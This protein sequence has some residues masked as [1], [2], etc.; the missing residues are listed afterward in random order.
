MEKSWIA[1]RVASPLCVYWIQMVVDSKRLYHGCNVINN[2]SRVQQSLF[3]TR[4][5]SS[6]SDCD[7]NKPRYDGF[8]ENNRS[9]VRTVHEK[10]V[11]SCAGTE[12]RRSKR[13]QT[14]NF[15]GPGE[16]VGH[17][18]V[19]PALGLKDPHRFM[20]ID[21]LIPTARPLAYNQSPELFGLHRHLQSRHCFRGPR[22]LLAI[23][24]HELP[25]QFQPLLL[26]E[27]FHRRFPNNLPCF[28][29]LARSILHLIRHELPFL[30]HCD[31]KE[32]VLS[33]GMRIWC[34]DTEAGG[35]HILNVV[36]EAVKGR[37]VD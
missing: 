29:I 5:S 27:C 17:L 30:H 9:V 13:I 22:L 7:Q 25:R 31:R 33:L 16:G 19:G 8:K 6:S 24:L 4:T 14:H 11:P 32:E 23:L 12:R 20:K 35:I 37:V 15:P 21:T 10:A 2:Y 36:S 28:L 18:E 26:P 3:L 34:E 1:H